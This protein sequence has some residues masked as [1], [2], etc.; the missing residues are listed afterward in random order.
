MHAAYASGDAL[1]FPSTTETLGFAALEAFASGVPVVAAKAGGLSFVVDDGTT[2]FLVEPSLPDSAWAEKLEQLLI[3]AP[4]HTQMAQAARAEAE[5][6]NWR[7]STE[8]V[9]EVYKKAITAR[10]ALHR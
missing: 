7:T 2:G 4:L 6:W 10:R 8:A 9:V 1:L 5:R 3:D